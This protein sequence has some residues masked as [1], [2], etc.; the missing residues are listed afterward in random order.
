MA[1]DA[2]E[3]S[4]QYHHLCAAWYCTDHLPGIVAHNPVP[5]QQEG[6]ENGVR[7]RCGVWCGPQVLH[8]PG[9]WEYY[10]AMR[11]HNPLLPAD[12]LWNALLLCILLGSLQSNCIRA[13]SSCAY[14]NR[15]C[16]AR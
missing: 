5:A 12:S 11:Q 3:D 15:L 10:N 6:A 7:D 1:Y 14:Y 13:C 2:G 16:Q 9:M 4:E 8:L